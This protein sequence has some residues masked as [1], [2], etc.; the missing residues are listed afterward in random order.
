MK[1]SFVYLA[2]VL[3]LV[4]GLNCGSHIPGVKT[5]D[6]AKKETTPK[7]EPEWPNE[8]K[9]ILYKSS[10]D[11]SDQPALFYD[12][13]SK[14]SK[15]LLVALHTWSIDHLNDHG[16]P[17]AKWCISKDWVLIY[18]YFRGPNN[19]PDA[20]G[21][22]LVVNDIKSAVRY[23]MEHSS[24]DPGR[25]YLVGASGGGYTSLLVAGK[26]PE[27]WAGVSAWVPITDLKNW[28][29]ESVERKKKYA[30]DIVASCGGVPEAS[31]AVAKEYFNRSPINFLQN[32]KNIPLD[33]NAGIHDG[34]SGSV[35]ISHTI[36]AFNVLAPDADKISETD[37][38][39]FVNQQKVPQALQGDFFDPNYD[40]NKVLFRRVSNKTR[41]TIFEGGHEIIFNAA[42]KWLEKQRKTM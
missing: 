41:V 23:A 24:I 38:D 4:L 42:L 22:D 36:N 29:Y 31:D 5:K 10:A 6:S 19:N 2:A 25:I 39:F 40:E 27:L 37:I 34:H 21:S 18:P 7:N 12:S 26:A 17:Y 1:K 20:T 32:A 33:I 15:P 13:G 30:G 14:K 11:N 3:I 28:Y 35:P 9:D 16:V 8:V